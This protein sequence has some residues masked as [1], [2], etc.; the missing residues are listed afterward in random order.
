MEK[1]DYYIAQ[2]RK[3]IRIF[4]AGRINSLSLEYNIPA[5]I[6]QFPDQYPPEMVRRAQEIITERENLTLETLRKCLHP[7]KLEFLLN[8]AKIKNE[9]DL[10]RT[11]FKYSP[12]DMDNILQAYRYY[13]LQP[14]LKEKWISHLNKK[15]QL[16]LSLKDLIE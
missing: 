12:E 10:A 6:Y 3:Y 11:L 5:T 14:P 7:E 15:L 8:S 1:L 13:Q 16:E 4:E 2:T 9:G